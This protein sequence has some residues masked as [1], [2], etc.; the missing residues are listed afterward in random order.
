MKALILMALLLALGCQTPRNSS[1]VAPEDASNNQDEQAIRE[2]APVPDPPLID[3]LPVPADALQSF[4]IEM[5]MIGVTSDETCTIEGSVQDIVSR[6]SL[7]GVSVNLNDGAYSGKT[8]NGRFKITGI[9]DG[10]Y[11]LQFSLEGYRP[12]IHHIPLAP[13]QHLGFVIGLA[14]DGTH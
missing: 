5:I 8:A 11:T 12:L 2:E 1:S 13:G 14:P 7:E 3:T 6:K 4:I 10:H 9:A